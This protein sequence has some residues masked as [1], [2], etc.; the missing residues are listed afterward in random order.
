MTRST[1]STI[2]ESDTGWNWQEIWTGLVAAVF[3]S[4]FFLPA[5]SAAQGDTL[6]IVGLWIVCGL[7]WTAG[8]W[9][10]TFPRIHWDW[11]D[12]SAAVWIGGQVVSA[13][14]VILTAGEKRSA[15]NMAWEWLAIGIVWLI[16]RHGIVERTARN[17]FLQAMIVTG[18]VLGAYG[19]YQHYVMHP[20]LVAE[21]GPLFE[22]LHS[23]DS[24]ANFIRQKL[25]RDGIPTEGPALVLFER[26]LLDS[27][28]PLGL[29]ALANTF[30]GLLAVCLLLTL[31]EIL[32]RRQSGTGWRSRMPCLVVAGIVGWCLLL[33]KS[34]TAWI[35][36]VCGLVV[37]AAPQFRMWL[38]YRRYLLPAGI[39][40]AV[41][42]VV[43]AV[44]F[45]QGGLDQ[46]VLSEAPKSLAYRIQYWQATCRLIAEHL[47]LGVGPGNFRQHY[48]KYKLPK[49]S[50]EIADPHNLFFEVTATGGIVSAAGLAIFLG[51]A[52]GF[53][54]R[55]LPM[56]S[57]PP[58]AS[59]QLP[60]A[61]WM[62]GGG[63]ILAFLG[64]LICWQ[65][66]EDRVLVLA[67]VWMVVAWLFSPGRRPI[68]AGFSPLATRHSPLPLS[69]P[70]RRPIVASGGEV[71]NGSLA[72][73]VALAVHLMGAGGIAMPGVVQVLVALL[74]LSLAP[75]QDPNPAPPRRRYG[76]LLAGAGSLVI[77]V[78]LMMT[79]LLPVWRCR[80]AMRD[81]NAAGMSSAPDRFEA[82]MNFYRAAATADSWSPEPWRYQ[83][84]WLTTGI[85]S[86]ERNETAVKQLHEVMRRDPVNFWA[87]QALGTW[88]LQKW[89]T[90]HG[91]DDALQA[92]RW[93][94]R[95]QQLYPTNSGIQAKLAFA[96]DSA[97]QRAEAIDAAQ[98]ALAQDD[99]YHQ[100]GHIDRYLDDSTRQ[101]LQSLMT[102][103][104]P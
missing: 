54:V 87:P 37:L 18:V 52:F 83:F 30:G 76:A 98:A 62:A 59:R 99:I 66:W 12:A 7:A 4:R 104:P 95:A 67:V 41:I 8:A 26:R 93:L 17:G 97:R 40:I 35:G 46:Q 71:L 96:L 51:L 77:L 82:A 89:R 91:H 75:A 69:D 84:E 10:G 50:E 2:A 49:A 56:S 3:F 102:G 9:R 24:N 44:L 47:W 92:V 20:R 70:E 55:R 45:S 86:N 23:G 101:Q 29:F 80:Q 1:E 43:P 53:A 36:C 22:K 61:F 16:L 68:V 100:N 19:L 6:W 5:E 64:P 94:R 78:A 15:A 103:S 27:R 79:S 25:A 11:L 90:T 28:E 58:S 33:T 21:Y 73:A 32:A 38:N 81:G 13:V 63:A 48:L 42:L 57:I 88:W 74:A 39:T 34:R 72:A 14:V 60:L 31:G 65:E 85:L